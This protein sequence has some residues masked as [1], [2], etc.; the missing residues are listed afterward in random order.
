MTIKSRWSIIL[1]LV[2]TISISACSTDRELEISADMLFF[3][4]NII[5][6]EDEDNKIEALAIKDGK[7]VFSGSREQAKSYQ[8]ANTRVIE[9]GNKA[10][11]PG[12]IDAHGHF[13]ATARFIN[14]ANLS[15]PPVGEVNNIDGLIIALR[16]YVAEQDT[17]PEWIIGYGYDE[18]L[19]TE[20]RH[21]TRADLDK[22]SKQIPITVIH[23]SVHLAVVN[24]A[25][26]SPKGG[27]IRRMPD[28]L[29]PNGVL[30]ETAAH[31]AFY[32]LS[33]ISPLQ[34]EDALRKTADYYTS[35]GITTAQD[36]ASNLQDLNFLRSIFAKQ[37]LPIEIS[38][39]QHV[40]SEKQ[41]ADAKSE[42]TYTNGVKLSGVKFVVDGSPQGRTAWLSKPY[43][44]NDAQQGEDYVAYPTVDKDFY[45]SAVKKL[46]DKNVQVIS[47]ANGDAAIDLVLQSLQEGL[48]DRAPLDHRSVI[49][50]AQLMRK[51]QV[52]TAK[53]VSA[54]PSFFSSH[55]FFWGDWHR[56]NFGDERASNISPMAWAKA[57]DLVY[58]IHNDAPVV[59]PN[60]L[61]LL[62]ASTN[63]TTRSGYIL[64]ENQQ[65]SVKDALR[66]ITIN[67]AYQNFE[68]DSK[69]SLRVGKQA[70][71]VILD[72]N[73]LT[74]DKT[75][76][77]QIK[78]L[79]TIAHGKTVFRAP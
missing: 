19:L 70:D 26:L 18:S 40:K 24:S 56:L 75:I 50:H 36:G 27:V 2:L 52:D 45:K 69:G 37:A 54:I 68:E 59:P 31:M 49:I 6:M 77:D 64:G 60:M 42:T 65:A 57:T 58:T 28:S 5:T 41:L 16:A 67:A 47:H 61:H 38:L 62:W 11:M 51:D 12:F 44:S 43:L 66:A 10:L 34:F 35:F 4:D 3:G 30:E 17:P 22:V 39:Y 73:P 74:I 8:G 63:R 20:K 23:V 9:L 46:L 76:L 72:R 48:A 21:P 14:F 25:A 55:P 32:P 71:L 15:S 13:S 53:R 29:E 7:I 1:L 79:E 78:V 33:K